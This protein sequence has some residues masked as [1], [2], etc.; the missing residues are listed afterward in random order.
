[1]KN[2]FMRLYDYKNGILDTIAERRA[3]DLEAGV[4]VSHVL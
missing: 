4:L 3:L 1:M 2:N